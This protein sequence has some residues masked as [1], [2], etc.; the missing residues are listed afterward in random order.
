MSYV[1]IVGL[2]REAGIISADG[3][4]RP[5]QVEVQF[6]QT[7]T[8]L[9]MPRLVAVINGLP[10]PRTRKP[11]GAAPVARRGRPRPEQAPLLADHPFQG[12]GDAG[13]FAATV[14]SARGCAAG[15]ELHPKEDA[16]P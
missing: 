5:A 13:T 9:D 14:C 12:L 16:K 4:E 6:R 11:R 3:A 8:E 15:P 1:V 10:N 2:E 7:V